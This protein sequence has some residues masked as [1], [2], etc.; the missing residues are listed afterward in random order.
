MPGIALIAVPRC[1]RGEARLRPYEMYNQSMHHRGWVFLIYALITLVLS[2]CG[3]GS[4]SPSAAPSS[5]DSALST[6]QSAPTL[7]ELQ[8]KLA[9]EFDRLGIDPEKVPAA[10]ASGY[11]AAVFDLAL[12]V[13]DPDG[14]GGDPPIGV[15]LTWTECMGADYNQDGLVSVS[16]LT[17]IGQHFREAVEYD[18]PSDHDDFEYWPAGDP[19]DGGAGTDN[20]RL[21]RI[22]GNGDGLIEVSDIT[23]LALHWNEF[24]SGYVIE[25]AVNLG[26]GEW[27]WDADWVDIGN[28]TSPSV[29][30]SV[31]YLPGE[32]AVDP[33]LPVRYSV[34][35]PLDEAEHAQYF[36]VRPY[37]AGTDEAG[38]E[39][40][41]VV[42]VP[43]NSGDTTP[44]I[45][46][47]TVGV[48]G[49][50]PSAGQLIVEFGTAEDEQSPPV[51]YRVYWA[52]GDPE[53]PSAVFDYAT[54]E[55]AD[56][57]SAPYVITGLTD[58]QYYRVAARA[59]DSADTPNIELNDV[60]LAKPA[61]ATD[62]YPPEWINEPGITYAMMADG[63][64]IVAFGRAIDSHTDEYGTWESGPVIYRIYH[65][66]GREPDW[67][68]AE[69]V[70]RTDTGL[71]KYLAEL[72]GVDTSSP[73]WFAVRAIDQANPANEDDND[74]YFVAPGIEIERNP[75]P[76][77]GPGITLTSY[78][79][80]YWFLRHPDYDGIG[81]LRVLDGHSEDEGE[82]EASFYRWDGSEFQHVA[83]Y[84]EITTAGLTARLSGNG[85]LIL[86]HTER[87]GATSN[88][89]LHYNNTE[90]GEKYDYDFSPKG[91]DLVTLNGNFK[92]FVLLH[93]TI[94]IIPTVIKQYFSNY[95]FEDLIEIS[96]FDQ[97]STFGLWHHVHGDRHDSR[98]SYWLKNAEDFD[99]YLARNN[100][101]LPA[102]EYLRIACN[103]GSISIDHP[104]D[105]TEIHLVP[106]SV[107][108]M[109]TDY[110]IIFY[111][112]YYQDLPEETDKYVY[113]EVELPVELSFIFSEADSLMFYDFTSESY[114]LTNLMPTGFYQT[115]SFIESSGENVI[116]RIQALVKN[117]T[118]IVYIPQN[119]SL[120]KAEYTNDGAGSYIIREINYDTNQEYISEY[121]VIQ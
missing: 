9:V 108:G 65:G 80:D 95:P 62:I 73:R 74:S 26:T 3:G 5:Q 87:T 66:P 75:V 103:A 91:I 114:N 39:S 32:L 37:D 7:A 102:Q 17:P 20:W 15:E 104:Y 112:I 21:A 70:E 63:K 13:I 27:I 48:T 30:R 46:I 2:A 105:D 50:V 101:E 29:P 117:E 34:T 67:E 55:T 61:G 60:V 8:A 115:S 77:L 72:D 56:T 53:Q 24:L 51:S 44:P 22:D 45:W 90:T 12:T 78:S 85:N 99:F 1:H 86:A 40:N 31:N 14:E 109:F 118:S 113:G 19:D 49:L 116:G 88:G 119:I 96:H 110:P 33:N 23:P 28:G 98:G 38:W 107:L 43:T 54:A 121:T 64:V 97:W 82:F 111:S 36:R 92:P 11:E 120:S 57:A 35:V 16:D 71:E 6:G 94:S 58:G 18:D 41:N 100:S 89:L 83:D 106:I 4:S 25:R 84:P 59:M 79:E 42:Y 81:L 93:E 47:D 76:E 68:N 52:E 10:V 69:V